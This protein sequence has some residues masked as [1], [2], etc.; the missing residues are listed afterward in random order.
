VSASRSL[1]RTNKTN[2]MPR[3]GFAYSLTPDTVVRGGYGIFYE[4]IGVVYSHVNQTG[5]SRNTE[6]VPS[7]DNGQNFI[8][9]L[10]NPFPGGFLSPLGAAGGLS[11]NLGQGVSFFNPGLLNPYMQRWQLAVQRGLG[12]RAVV[13]VSYVGNRGT[14]Q[15]V[16]RDLDSLSNQ[17]LSRS[18]VRD[19]ATIDSLNA[20]VPNPFYP[21][22]PRTNLAG[23]TTSRAQL[24][25]PFPHFTGVSLD[26]NQGYS[27]YHSMQV[28]FERRFSAGLSSTLSYTWSKLMEARGYLN[29]ADAMP[30]E[31][32]SDQDRTHR[33]ALT[34]LYELPFG[35]GRRWAGPGNAFA[36][37]LVGGWQIQ[38][39][40]TTQSGPPLGFG[41]AIFTGNL[42]DVELPRGQ[43]TVERWFNVDAGFERNNAR[44][45]GSNVRTLNSRFA[46]IRGDGGNNWDLSIIKNT[47]LREGVTLQFRAEAINA[48][49]HPQFLA[50]NT[51]PTS[52]AFGQVT[53]EWTWP[54]VI[55]FGLK[56]LF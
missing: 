9:N 11:T 55:Q 53:G 16:G 4:P 28:R 10:T 29:G 1:W 34:W 25:R 41:N 36:S 12:G 13:E 17:Y 23:T 18:P 51:T 43:R 7:V 45:L 40:L 6:L 33:L 50:P 42:K 39:I 19:Q 44:Q 30:E 49:N 35:P 5:F 24:L 22:L 2:F 15:R 26:T 56:I 31:V 32:I 52:T 20:A 38:G 54:R 14:R 3:F 47:S 27:W 37:R 8:A 21:L 46:G 48:L